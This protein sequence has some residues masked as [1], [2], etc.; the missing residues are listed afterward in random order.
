MSS[1]SSR[2]PVN[3]TAAMP[4]WFV[5]TVSLTAR[6]LGTSTT[7][8]PQARR[9][10]MQ[11]SSGSCH[12]RTKNR[13]LIQWS[14]LNSITSFSL[15]F[16]NGMLREPKFIRR[17]YVTLWRLDVV[18][19]QYGRPKVLQREGV[20]ALEI[21]VNALSTNSI[22]NQSM[23]VVFQRVGRITNDPV[24]STRGLLIN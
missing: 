4:P 21:I 10:Q 1:S 8:K 23:D 17:S 2:A 7:W 16:S 5:A 18:D 3:A 9:R 13:T 6:G 24:M 15:L 14:R 12:V 19:E 11:T 20:Y 22:L